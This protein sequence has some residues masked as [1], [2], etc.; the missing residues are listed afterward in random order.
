MYARAVSIFFGPAGETPLMSALEG[1]D[2]DVLRER[3]KAFFAAR[4]VEQTLSVPYGRQGEFAALREQP[5]VI[6]EDYGATMVVTVRGTPE[7]LRRLAT[8]L[9][10]G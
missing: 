7:T 6:R 4:L 5:D 2:G 1:R 10:S 9:D 3:I 8:R